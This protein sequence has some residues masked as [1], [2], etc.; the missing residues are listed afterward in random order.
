M[1]KLL[2]ISVLLISIFTYSN[3]NATSFTVIDSFFMVSGGITVY[4][5]L[6]LP[7]YNEEYSESSSTPLTGN[8]SDGESSVWSEASFEKVA[9]GGDSSTDPECAAYATAITQV[10]FKPNFI[11]QGDPITF[12]VYRMLFGGNAYASIV[13]LIA[14]ETI[15]SKDDAYFED[16]PAIFSYSGWNPDHIYSLSMSAS[17]YFVMNDDGRAGATNDMQFVLPVPEPVTMLLLGTGLVGLAG[18]KRKFR[19]Q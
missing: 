13:D 8:L 10:L 6:H 5:Y 17:N 18:L 9:T 1:K 16:P 4:D 2:M 3:V 19:K 14:G 7:I 12:Y 15:F 11:G